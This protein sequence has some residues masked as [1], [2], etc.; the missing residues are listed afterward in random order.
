MSGRVSKAFKWGVSA[1]RVAKVRAAAGGRMKVVS[2]KPLYLGKGSR[3][4]L[5]EGA[6]LT[7]GSGVY[8]SPGC[9]VEVGDGANLAIEDGVYMNEGCRVTVVESARIGA[10]TL[11]GPNVQVYDH[12]HEFDRGGGALGAAPCTRV[13]RAALLAVRQRRRHARLLGRGPLA[14]VG[15]LRRHAGPCGGRR[16]VR[17]RACAADQEIR[18]GSL[19]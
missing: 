15:E 17:G 2:G 4:V 13:H 5:G 19:R 11:F 8:L 18:I 7:V 12:D 1:L 16:P 14:R 9:V 6:R 3:V 10:D